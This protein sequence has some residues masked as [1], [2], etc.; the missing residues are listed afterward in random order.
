MITTVYDFMIEIIGVPPSGDAKTWVYAGA[1]FL[2][3]SVFVS[4]IRLFA[5]VFR[6]GGR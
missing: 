4:I 5:T 6:L 2:V 3:C 1:V